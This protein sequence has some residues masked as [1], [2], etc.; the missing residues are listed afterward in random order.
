MQELF[1]NTPYGDEW[2]PVLDATAEERCGR[3]MTDVVWVYR[4]RL[5]Q[6]DDEAV[7]AGLLRDL[8]HWAD[9]HAVEVES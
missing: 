6:M 2:K 1:T 9:V 4:T 8:R 3:A 5:G 7:V